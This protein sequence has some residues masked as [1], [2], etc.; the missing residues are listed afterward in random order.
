M[1]TATTNGQKLVAVTNTA[2]KLTANPT[3]ASNG[4]VIHALAGN[5][6]T[7]VVGNSGVTTSNG[8]VLA[9][10]DAVTVGAGDVSSIYI[11]GTAGDGVS[12]LAN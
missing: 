2:I 7:I 11:N 5:S 12:W 4:V 9:A 1:A 8:L 10:G 6:T 3:Q